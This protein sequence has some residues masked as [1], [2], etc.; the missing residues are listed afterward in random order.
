M[1]KF[2]KE[3]MQHMEMYKQLQRTALTQ[4]HEFELKEFIH[5][6][7][8]IL[9]NAFIIDVCESNENSTNFFDI[10]W[11]KRTL[12][13]IYK[14]MEETYQTTYSTILTVVTVITYI[15]FNTLFSHGSYAA[16]IKYHLSFIDVETDYTYASIK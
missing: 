14:L 8:S 15:Q 12:T 9:Q 2:G 6:L 11:I 5:Y 4:P 1:N 13:S 7:I 10:D 3:T 16:Y